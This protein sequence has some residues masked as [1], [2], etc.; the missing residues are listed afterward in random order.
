MNH[1]GTESA[2]FAVV[3]IGN[4]QIDESRKVRPPEA[5]KQI[6]A[7]FVGNILAG[8]QLQPPV[9]DAS[10]AVPAINRECPLEQGVE[11]DQGRIE[12]RRCIT[13]AFT[14]FA[15]VAEIWIELVA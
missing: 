7:L 11:G 10:E 13:A 3:Q 9:L 6:A 8:D 4:D 5:A 2:A 15:R 14:C 12:F 1:D